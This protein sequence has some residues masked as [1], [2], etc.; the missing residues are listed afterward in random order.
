MRPFTRNTV[1]VCLIYVLLVGGFALWQRREVGAAH[2]AALEDPARG[3]ERYDQ[4]M[5]RLGAGALGV[6]ALVGVLGVA[7]YVRLAR[8]GREVA[9]RLQG[10]LAG[11]AL[12]AP[13]IR[14][15]LGA[16]L[17]AADRVGQELDLERERGAQ[18]RQRLHTLSR[19]MDVGVLL[20]NPSHQL[21]FANPR[22][23]ELLGCEDPAQ[24]HERWPELLQLLDPG[25]PAQEHTAQFD[26]DVPGAKEPRAV[27]CRVYPLVEEEHQGFVCLLRERMA[28][29]ALETDLLLASQLRALSRVYLAVTHDLKAPLNAMV[30]NL[31]RLQTALRKGGGVQEAE[32]TQGYLDVLREELERLD[33]SLLAL[34]TDTT[35]AGSGREEFDVR[36]T[37]REIERLLLPQ[38]RQQHV[39]LEAQLPGVAVRI[40]GQRDRLKQAIL[41]VAINAL[42]AMSDGGE[43]EL[44]LE[45]LPE[46]AEVRISDTGPGIPEEVRRRIF[47]MHY[48]TKTTGTGIG[49]YLARSIVEAHGGEITV[50]NRPGRGSEFRL[51]LPA[52]G[53]GV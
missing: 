22:A 15:E 13:R 50:E 43:L 34:L 35:P 33:R 40:A 30:L 47:D 45:A 19:L 8:R 27:H 49:L 4:A 28:L 25:G 11:D 7:F 21:D 29:D 3:A 12:P 20:V 46:E 9:D 18:A 48:T 51:R 17:E 26:F 5:R 2:R 37:M 1:G 36:G 53:A 32:K 6:L 16:A 31:D 52:L 42:E 39:A 38:A 41:N 44:I 23:C 14:D 24:L 10:A